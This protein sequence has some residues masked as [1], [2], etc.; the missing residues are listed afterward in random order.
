MQQEC[1]KLYHEFSALDTLAT[2]VHH[3][4]TRVEKLEACVTSKVK[5]WHICRHQLLHNHV[6]VAKTACTL[7][8]GQLRD[9]VDHRDCLLGQSRLLLILRVSG[10]EN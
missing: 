2:D 10:F 9:A 5:V 3:L 8:S 7:C 1:Q 4:R 6:G